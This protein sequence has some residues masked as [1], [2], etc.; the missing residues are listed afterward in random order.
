MRRIV[1]VCGKNP[2]DIYTF[3]ET[4][5]LFIDFLINLDLIPVIQHSQNKSGYF[6]L[7]DKDN[8]YFLLNFELENSDLKIKIEDKEKLKIEI[9]NGYLVRLRMKSYDNRSKN[10]KPIPLKELIKNYKR[11]ELVEFIRNFLMNYF[12]PTSYII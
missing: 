10:F 1:A 3:P 8:N 7:K 9:K 2:F 6:L 11:N 12:S 5:H 4:F